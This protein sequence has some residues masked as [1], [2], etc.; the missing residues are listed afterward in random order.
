MTLD[1]DLRTT[2]LPAMRLGEN[3]QVERL[4]S[5]ES[6][7]PLRLITPHHA[8]IVQLHA[9]QSKQSHVSSATVTQTRHP[10]SSLARRCSL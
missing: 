7:L 1:D 9:R 5:L 8:S 6:V 4:I 3:R 10:T 2:T